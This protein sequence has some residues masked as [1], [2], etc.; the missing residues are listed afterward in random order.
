MLNPI[1]MTSWTPKVPP[2]VDIPHAQLLS[3]SVARYPAGV[4]PRAARSSAALS[5]DVAE[6]IDI[7][8]AESPVAEFQRKWGVRNPSAML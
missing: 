6:S 8:R 3:A 4:A 7:A 2:C 1:R 5:A